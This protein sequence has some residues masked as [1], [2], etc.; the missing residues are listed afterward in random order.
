[1]PGKNPWVGFGCTSDHHR[2]AAGLFQHASGVSR[3]GNVAVADNRQVLE[4]SLELGDWL[5]LSRFMVR[6]LTSTP[7]KRDGFGAVFCR[8]VG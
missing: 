1:M 7:M 6:N 3:G 2:V 8:E 5:P 4:G